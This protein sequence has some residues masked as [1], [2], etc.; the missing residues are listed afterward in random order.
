MAGHEIDGGRSATPWFGG[1]ELNIV[2]ARLRDTLASIAIAILFILST[3]AGTVS[4][5]FVPQTENVF[6]SLTIAENM[7]MGAFPSRSHKKKRL[8][9]TP[10]A[11]ELPSPTSSIGISIR[12]RVS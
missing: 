3:A 12:P 2:V 6:P 7:H 4:V 10:F 8:P 9:Y 11:G 5:G 1:D